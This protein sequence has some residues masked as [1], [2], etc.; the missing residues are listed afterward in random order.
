M[1]RKDVFVCHSTALMKLVHILYCISNER[2]RC[3]GGYDS[4]DEYRRELDGHRIQYGTKDGKQHVHF[5]FRKNLE[6]T[7]EVYE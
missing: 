2:V 7:F 4:G 3:Y 6:I 5:E 1:L